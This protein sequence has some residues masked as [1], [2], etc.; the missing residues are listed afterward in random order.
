VG[1]GGSVVSPKLELKGVSKRFRITPGLRTEIKVLEDISLQVPKGGFAAF[2]GPSGCGKST[3]LRVIAGLEEAS[4]GEV[5]IDGVVSDG[6]RVQVGMV[7][8]SYSSFPWLTVRENVALGLSLAA[9]R[10]N[11][12]SKRTERVWRMLQ[13]VGLEEFAE[14]FPKNLSGGMK[15]RLA[16]ARSLVVEPSLLLLDEPFGSLDAQTRLIL[17]DQLMEIWEHLDTTVCLVTH[18]VEEALLL[19]DLVYVLSARPATVRKEIKNPFPAPRSPDLRMRSDF[20]SIK[21]E[22]FEEIRADA[23]GALRYR[24]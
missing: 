3:L 9:N 1:I 15:Q 7:F 10:E 21:R 8:Q 19:A 22:I 12:G 13:L 4:A 14:V 6:I 2:I 24:G 16:L 20:L 5:L 18:D 17:Q 23:V 11:H